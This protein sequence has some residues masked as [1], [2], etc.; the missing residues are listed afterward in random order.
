MLALGTCNPWRG[1]LP[2]LLAEDHKY[3]LVTLAYVAVTGP[4]LPTSYLAGRCFKLL[5]CL[6]AWNILGASGGSM[7]CWDGGT[8]LCRR[9]PYFCIPFMLI[10]FPSEVHPNA[11]SRMMLSAIDWTSFQDACLGLKK[12]RSGSWTGWGNEEWTQNRISWARSFQRQHL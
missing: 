5:S 2:G 10:S 9:P 8:S 12:G 6:Q 4:E 3:A 11:C 7:T 1:W